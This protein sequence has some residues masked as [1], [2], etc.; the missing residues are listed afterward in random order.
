MS[1]HLSQ[2]LTEAKNSNTKAGLQNLIANAFFRFA[3]AK[4]PDT[5]GMLMLIGAL[6]ILNSGDDTHTLNVARRMATAAMSR[7]NK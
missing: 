7:S 5:K 3:N 4:D 6:T 1:K 2:I